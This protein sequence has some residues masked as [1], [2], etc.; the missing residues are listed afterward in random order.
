MASNVTF[1]QYIPLV[2]DLQMTAEIVLLSSVEDLVDAVRL[3]I[4]TQLITCSLE[5]PSTCC[6]CSGYHVSCEMIPLQAHICIVVHIE[7]TR[8]SCTTLHA[9]LCACCELV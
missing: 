4:H 6:S 1:A 9:S 5:Y 3:S 8:L 2:K 7:S